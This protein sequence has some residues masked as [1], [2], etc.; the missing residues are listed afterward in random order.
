MNNTQA[1]VERKVSEKIEQVRSGEL[2]IFKALNPYYGRW[3]YYDYLH[4]SWQCCF[5]RSGG[6]SKSGQSGLTVASPTTSTKA[7]F[8]V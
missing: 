8:P 5:N 4:D 7:G 3:L 6:N 2:S 1:E